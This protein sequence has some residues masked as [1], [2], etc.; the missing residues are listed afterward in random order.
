M[1][2]CGTASRVVGKDALVLPGENTYPLSIN[3]NLSVEE[4]VARGRYWR[5]NEGITSE[6][7]S[8]E[9]RGTAHLTVRLIQFDRTVSQKAVCCKLDQLDYRPLELLEL[10]AFG[11]KY[12]DVHLEFAPIVALGS[13]FRRRVNGRNCHFVPFLGTSVDPARRFLGLPFW[14]ETF[15]RTEWG[16]NT[17]FAAVHK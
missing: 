14:A 4:A 17:R 11:A 13:V 15:N 9:R 16:S 8:T 2:K 3:Y 5:E 10:L 12:P 6:H 7:F 1:R